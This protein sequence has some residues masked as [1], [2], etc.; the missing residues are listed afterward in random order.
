MKTKR[1]QIFVAFTFFMSDV[2]F[3]GADSLFA[4]TCKDLTSDIEKLRAHYQQET[5]FLKE[6]QNIPE[7]QDVV[8]SVEHNLKVTKS[9][10]EV[11]SKH[12][13]SQGCTPNPDIA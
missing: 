4:K 6:H 8:R 1:K 12:Y 9:Q 10:F 13:R 7:Y 2:F 11:F 5:S 3:L